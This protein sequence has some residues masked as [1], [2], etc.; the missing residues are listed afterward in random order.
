MVAGMGRKRPDVKMMS[1]GLYTP[2]DKKGKALPHILEFT[3]TIP[4]RLEAEFGYIL[5]IRKARGTILWF[6]IDHPPFAGDDGEISPP[7][8]GEL[9]GPDR[10]YLFFLGDPFWTPLESKLG[11]WTLRTWLDDVLVAEKS[12]LMVPADME[13]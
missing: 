4:V 5:R 3:E 12:F 7:F 13:R 11:D 2:F 8:T 6:E 1:Y 10:A 9:R